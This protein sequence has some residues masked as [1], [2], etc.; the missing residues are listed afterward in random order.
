MSNPRIIRWIFLAGLLA[1]GALPQTASPLKG[2]LI[3]TDAATQEPTAT[4]NLGSQDGVVNKMWFDVY[5]AGSVLHLPLTGE[6][7]VRIPEVVGQI[8]ITEIVSAKESRGIVYPRN[9]LT[10]IREGSVVIGFP[11]A[12]SENLPPDIKEVVPRPSGEPP[13]GTRVRIEATVVDP[14]GDP[15]H[16]QW[17]AETGH[18]GWERSTLPYV[19]WTAPFQP[20]PHTLSVQAADAK[21]LSQS[22]TVSVTVKPYPEDHRTRPY[23]ADHAFEGTIP[24]VQLSDLA[25]APDL[26]LYASDPDGC[27]IGFLPPDRK[28]FQAFGQRGKEAGQFL[29]PY[30]VVHQ[31][32]ALFVLD[33]D[34]RKVLRFTSDGTFQREFGEAGEGNGMLQDPI[35]L[36]VNPGGDLLILDARSADVQVFDP[37]GKFVLR[38]GRRGTGP[39]ELTAP[40]ALSCD[41]Q[42]NLYVLDP[43]RR[44]LL[45][46]D[47][48]YRLAQEFPSGEG[49]A[50]ALDPRQE[51][52]FL[53]AQSEPAVSRILLKDGQF[54]ETFGRQWENLPPLAKPGSPAAIGC[55]ELGI[56]WL[57]GGSSEGTTLYR[58]D[59]T[60]RFLGKR[61]GERIDRAERIAAGAGGDLYLLSPSEASV[62]HFDARGWLRNR[63]GE[64][65]SEPHQMRDPV[66]LEVD[67][68]GHLFI[69]DSKA[70]AIKEFDPMGRFLGAF[71]ASGKEP[72][73]LDHPA[74]MAVHEDLVLLL[75]TGRRGRIQVFDR[76]GNFQF[77]FGS[78]KALPNHLRDPQDLAVTPAGEVL[79]VLKEGRIQSH[80]ITD[81]SLLAPAWGQK[82]SENGQFR[83]ISGVAAD[84]A[85][86]CWIADRDRKDLQ[87]FQSS[88]T[89]G[90][91]LTLSDPRQIPLPI[92]VACDRL[93]HLYVLDGQTHQ[94]TVCIQP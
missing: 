92:D 7:I 44:R 16:F 38:L 28:G 66:D 73:R 14:D 61:G 89:G 70:D 60:G 3:R 65:G 30:R 25:V 1:C 72:G 80:R 56:L 58:Y 13:E 90:H 39:G 75:E 74:A 50:F 57:A 24:F 78:D 19:E 63:F 64:K 40:S 32:K 6:E 31:D 67:R 91:L 93:N 35:D 77:S 18:L 94:V 46:F 76:Q 51:T 49:T 20:G 59:E 79:V 41:G 69:L 23:A 82:G 85:G 21:G 88:P 83:R 36:A 86:T 45:R 37:E 62:W 22:K 34:R 2:K 5:D 9:D 26:T 47:R 11:V 33:R 54:D 87:R 17:K 53:M 84:A 12:T 68:R 8:Q 55:D 48:S 15:V 29:R 4:V 81:G 10:Q 43:G 71:G 42:G 52:A 27:R